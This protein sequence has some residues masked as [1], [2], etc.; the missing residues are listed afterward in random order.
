MLIQYMP[1]SKGAKASDIEYIINQKN[2]FAALEL[3]SSSEEEQDSVKSVHEGLG[4]SLKAQK[5]ELINQEMRKWTNTVSEPHVNI[6]N[7]PFYK[8]KRGGFKHNTR[9]R[10]VDEDTT[11]LEKEAEQRVAYE[12]RPSFLR[13]YTNTYTENTIVIPPEEDTSTA[14]MW[15]DKVKEC[16]EKAEAARAKP[17]DFHES[18][19]RLSFFRRPIAK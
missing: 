18:L 11:N 12:E 13:E 2:R 14:A 6:F 10:F 16:L 7:S 1:K 19:N 17:D 4:N 5:P 8:H 15:A 3:Y 9:P